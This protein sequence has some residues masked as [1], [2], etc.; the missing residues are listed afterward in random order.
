MIVYGAFSVYYI[1]VLCGFSS[2]GAISQYHPNGFP[3]C[4]L[5]R[6]IKGGGNMEVYLK[7]SMRGLTIVGHDCMG[8]ND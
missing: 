5:S 2:V 1:F 8:L 4:I 6:R 7:T 3:H